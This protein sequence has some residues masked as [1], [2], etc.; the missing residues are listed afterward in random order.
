MTNSRRRAR[1]NAGWW[2]AAAVLVS[3]CLADGM[4][5]GHLN[6]TKSPPQIGSSLDFFAGALGGT[7]T[8]DA[9]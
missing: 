5:H 2:R 8:C 9:L 6:L 7:A 4:L 1:W 3:S